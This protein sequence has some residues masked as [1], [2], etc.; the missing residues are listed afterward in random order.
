MRK[1]LRATIQILEKVLT[2]PPSPGVNVLLVGHPGGGKTTAPIDIA[3]RRGLRYTLFD[4]SDPDGVRGLRDFLLPSGE[5]VLFDPGHLVI[6]D[7]V[8]RVEQDVR[9][10]LHS[11]LANRVVKDVQGRARPIRCHVVAT[12]NLEDLGCFD[13]SD[14][15]VS[16]FNIVVEVR[17]DAEDVKY[18][19]RKRYGDLPDRLLDAL[20]THVRRAEE[21]VG[22]WYRDLR[23]YI[24]VYENLRVLPPKEAL[25]ATFSKYAVLRGRY[26]EFEKLQRN[27]E[28]IASEFAEAV[29]DE[30]VRVRESK[31]DR[32]IKKIHVND[33]ASVAVELRR[34]FGGGAAMW[35]LGAMIRR[36]RRDEKRVVRDGKVY[37]LR[38]QGRLLTVEE[39]S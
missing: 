20:L 35:F 29:G 1:T 27:L 26:E 11:F 31:R 24:G 12:M 32:V 25:L 8:N 3:T 17:I 16:R 2:T 23:N 21:A 7:E 39:T 30:R 19:L 6:L 36:L 15:F 33:V 5:K 37:V 4:I 10:A 13:L 9:N 38:L 22:L 14:A 18:V 34:E 28:P